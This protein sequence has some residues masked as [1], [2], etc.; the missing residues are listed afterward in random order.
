MVVAYAGVL[1]ATQNIFYVKILHA[2]AFDP[3]RPPILQEKSVLVPTAK[4]LKFHET[5]YR[6][7]SILSS[8]QRKVAVINNQVVTVGDKVTAGESGKAT[9]IEIT[10]SE[11]TLSKA[12]REFVVRLPSSQYTKSAVSGL[13]EGLKDQP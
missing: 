8:G 2:D 3:T 1:F 13:T 6:V 10:T 11:V 9:V 5:D 7:T 4:P 12:Q